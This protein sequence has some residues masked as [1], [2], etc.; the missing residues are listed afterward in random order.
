[1]PKRGNA[2]GG[3]D[4]VTEAVPQS[5]HGLGTVRRFRVSVVEGTATGTSWTSDSDRCSIGSHPAN[6]VVVDDSAVSRFHCE[7]SVDATGPRIRDLDSRNGTAIDGLR[8]REAWLRTGCVIRIGRTSLSFDLATEINRVP[9]SDRNEFGSLIGASVG[10]R[11]AFAR[12]ERAANSDATILIEGE[13][14]TGKEEAARSLHAAGPRAAEPFVVIDCAAVPATILESELF[15]HEPASFTG[16]TGRR[17]GGFEAAGSGTVF[18]D[19]IGELPLDLQPKLLRVLE[20]REIRRVGSNQ[21]IPVDVRLVAATNRDL[22]TEVNAG[23]FR[24]DLYY[25]LAVLKIELPPLRTRPGDIAGLLERMLPSL[26]ASDEQARALQSPE[27]IAALKRASWPGNVRELRN[28]VE[29][30]LVFDEA[31]LPGPTTGARASEP[32][33]GIVED[34]VDARRDA[35]AAFERS[36]LESLLASFPSNISAAARAAGIDRNYLYRLMRRNNFPTRG[37]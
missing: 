17:V 27:H 32:G 16:A 19:E 34:F 29:R 23:S 1:M 6:D 15:G 10:M 12:L 33:T 9:L 11:A 30:C 8:V 37:K 4:L 35:L 5:S 13:T 14:G 31:P 2:A 26:G 7:I 24:T 25:R 22:R 20:R 21:Y 3:E 18:L 28:Y 36:Y